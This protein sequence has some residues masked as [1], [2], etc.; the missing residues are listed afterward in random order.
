MQG[1]AVNSVTGDGVGGTAEDVVLSFPNA[2]EVD[3]SSTS[4]K[5]INAGR[6]R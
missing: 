4:N 2:D 5:F 3:D 1:G 6:K